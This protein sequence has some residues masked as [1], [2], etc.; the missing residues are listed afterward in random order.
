MSRC[1]ACGNQ[2][3]SGTI[4]TF[5]DPASNGG[6]TQRAK[7]C[8]PCAQGGIVIVA[9][10]VPRHLLRLTPEPKGR[11]YTWTEEKNNEAIRKLRTYA[12]LARATG[13]K[14]TPGSP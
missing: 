11:Q 1:P 6:R 14:E 8:K 9:Q 5:I 7:V 4:V 3:R 2:Y 13:D 10:R 12:K